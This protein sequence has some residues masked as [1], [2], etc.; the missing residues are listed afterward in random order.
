MKLPRHTEESMCAM[1]LKTLRREDARMLT[2]DPSTSSA[3]PP[4]RK[5]MSLTEARYATAIAE[6]GV[7]LLPFARG[8]RLYDADIHKVSDCVS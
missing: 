6:E 4:Q 2:D 8:L 3:V 1:L 7:T 5:S